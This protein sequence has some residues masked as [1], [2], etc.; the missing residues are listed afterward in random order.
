ML[1]KEDGKIISDSSSDSAPPSDEEEYEEETIPEGDLFMVRRMLGSQA[2]DGDESQ[3]ENIFHTRC[4]IQ[5][6]VDQEK[7][8]AIQEWPTPKNVSE[9]RSFHGLASFYRRFVKDFSTM[10]APL[11]E[12]IKRHVGF[13]W[14]KKQ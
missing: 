13:T 14:G 9:V 5:G 11:N 6:K 1:V 2:I 8:K 4:L 3:R 7:V 10:A 12:V